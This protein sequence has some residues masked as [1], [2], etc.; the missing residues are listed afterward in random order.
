MVAIRVKTPKIATMAV[1]VVLDEFDIYVKKLDTV[2][3]GYEGVV[4]VREGDG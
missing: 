1:S 2:G 4:L 3:Y